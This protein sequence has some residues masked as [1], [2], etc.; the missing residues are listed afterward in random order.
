M[1]VRE[2]ERERVIDSKMNR[3]QDGQSIIGCYR[4]KSVCQWNSIFTD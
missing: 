4:H 2:R 3:G 1:C